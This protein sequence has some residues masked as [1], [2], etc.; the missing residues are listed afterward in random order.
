MFLE[1]LSG[2][3]TLF[4]RG[5]APLRVCRAVSSCLFAVGCRCDRR[6]IGGRHAVNDWCLF[7]KERNLGRQRAVRRPSHALI[8]GLQCVP[9]GLDTSTVARVILCS[10]F[11]LQGL[12]PRPKA[13][14]DILK[15]PGASVASSLR[16]AHNLT[17]VLSQPLARIYRCPYV[18]AVPGLD[19]VH[20]I[21][22]GGPV[23]H[24]C[25]AHIFFSIL[26]CFALPSSFK[27]S[28]EVQSVLSS[29][30]L[31]TYANPSPL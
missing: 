5:R 14:H 12:T 11:V 21:P 30:D 3:L 7:H 4:C 25:Q 31:D 24:C 20:V 13:A 16:S 6:I 15:V 10:P 26:M 17:I 18:R 8:Q 27:Q 19:P 22:R 28:I 23:G 2:R 29:V 1:F 9:S